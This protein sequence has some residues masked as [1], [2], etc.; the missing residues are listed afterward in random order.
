MKY[1]KGDIITCSNPS[2]KEYQVIKINNVFVNRYSVSA[3]R[4]FPNGNTYDFGS[5]GCDDEDIQDII[6]DSKRA[7][8]TQIN[9]ES[10]SSTI[11]KN[12]TSL[13]P[14]LII[15]GVGIYFLARR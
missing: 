4:Y 6:N 8:M 10:N 7:G 13:W 11:D 12:K 1:K 5:N 3:T 14:I 15:A 2:T 9:I